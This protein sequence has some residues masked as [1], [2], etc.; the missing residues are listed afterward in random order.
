M[1]LEALNDWNVWWKDINLLKELIGKQRETSLNL[2]NTLKFNEIKLITG[3]RRSGK[4]TYF[5][6][7]IN[8]LLNNG[9]KPEKILFINF[10]DEILSKKKLSEIFSIYQSNINANNEI[11][12]FLDEVHRCKEWELFVRKLYDTKQAAQIFITDS[13]SHFISREYAMLFTGRNIKFVFYPLSFKEYLFW[14]GIKEIKNISSFDKNKIKKILN[15]YRIYGGFPAVFFKDHNFKNILLK[16][17]FNDIL[18]LD[19]IDRFNIDINKARDLCLF[20]LSNIVRQFSV[21]NYSRQHNISFESIEKYLT[22]FEEVFFIFR[23]SRFNYSF[24]SQQLSQKKIYGIDN[25]L[26]NAVGFKFSQNLGQ[27][28]ENIV[29]VELK[30]QNKEIYYYG[31]KFECDFLIKEGIKI[32]QAIQVCYDVTQDNIKREINGLLEA[33]NQFKLKY[34]IIITDD[35][36]ETR[37]IKNK[38]IHFIPLW[39]WLLEH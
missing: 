39:K 10:E 11:Y 20:L 35:L 23:L 32:R 3:I 36:E 21:R 2:D 4:S 6:Q 12:L 25:G 15:E 5:Y 34:G 8:N 29:F 17:Y 28:Y 14:H 9:V 31:E 30:R 16:E 1:V 7:I 38:T 24:K 27:I 26:A 18:Y 37:K 33:M 13:S 22:C 19:I